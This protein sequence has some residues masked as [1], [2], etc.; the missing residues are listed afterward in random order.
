MIM[1]HKITYYLCFCWVLIQLCSCS[2]NQFILVHTCNEP[3]QVDGELN[4]YKQP[5]LQPDPFYSIQFS[6]SN[7]DHFFSYVVRIQDKSLQAQ[8]MS[9]G[10]TC[11]I[12]STGKRKEQFGIGFPIALTEKQLEA[13][14]IQ[15]SKKSQGVIDPIELDKAYAA[16][17]T[18]FDLIGF[19]EETFRMT[20]LSSRSIKTTLIFDELGAMVIE[21]RIPI[22]Q[23]ISNPNHSGILSIG[24]K[25]N[26]PE[27]NAD[28]DA[29]LFDNN[30]INPITQG[31]SMNQ[32]M[33][34]NQRLNNRPAF[35]GRSKMANLWSKVQLC[36]PQ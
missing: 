2:S 15:A 31:G 8:L 11:Y 13:V 18:E 12:D 22:D 21:V 36:A 28:D 32:M 27:A 1:L 17:C 19:G 3:I 26:E 30:Q 23:I 14:A 29:G 5:L 24:V 4:E 34:P 20:N 35:A 6:S 33:S 7:D 10:M 9:L 25:I 16:Q